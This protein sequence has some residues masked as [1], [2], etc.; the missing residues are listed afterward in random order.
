M[1]LWNRGIHPDA[2]KTMGCC[3]AGSN[4]HLHKPDNSAMSAE[5]NSKETLH[6]SIRWITS[7]L[8]C[9]PNRLR[10][11]KE[12]FGF[13]SFASFQWWGAAFRTWNC[14]RWNAACMLS[15]F[16]VDAKSNYLRSWDGVGCHSHRA[17]ELKLW[18]HSS[19]ELSMATTHFEHWHR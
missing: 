5:R 2:I 10:E 1:L 9:S 3:S 16:Q 6:V 8:T 11:L 14:W 18:W 4:D 13:A 19:D 7:R 15:E 12:F 17:A